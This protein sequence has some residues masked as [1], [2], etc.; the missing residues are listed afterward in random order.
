M[1]R[2]I[3][4]C[5]ICQGPVTVPEC[6]HGIHPP[7]PECSQCGAQP[8]NAFGPTIPMQP[9]RT[10]RRPYEWFRLDFVPR[11]SQTVDLQS[12]DSVLQGLGVDMDS[13][14]VPRWS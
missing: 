5:S 2:I 9:R 3:G 13:T 10:F 8:V 6:W 4:T 14:R 1:K 7:T 11:Q 12:W